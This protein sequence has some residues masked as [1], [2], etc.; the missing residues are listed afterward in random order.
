MSEQG[1]LSAAIE[2]GQCIPEI[3][4]ALRQ[5]R[6]PGLIPRLNGLRRL[7]FPQPRGLNGKRWCTKPDLKTAPG[8]SEPV[9]GRENEVVQHRLEGYRRIFRQRIPQRQCAMCRQLDEESI[10]QRFCN[11]LVVLFSLSRATR[12][13]NDRAGHRGRNLLASRRRRIGALADFWIAHR[14]LVLRSDITPIYREPALGIDADE[15]PGANDVGGIVDH[16]SVFESQQ[17]RFDLAETLVDR[18]GQLV[19]ILIFGL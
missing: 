9:I 12:D 16:G 1:G 11:V 6:F 15:D 3:V 17:R 7:A 4:L 8:R 19:R 10:R 18:V 5:P 13:R 14:C 2:G